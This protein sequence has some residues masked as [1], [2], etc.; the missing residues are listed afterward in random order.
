M[1][2]F[3]TIDIYF[4]IKYFYSLRIK[5]RQSQNSEEYFSELWDY[6]R[7]K[8]VSLEDV[9]NSELVSDIYPL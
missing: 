1:H 4:L 6:T 8:F 3:T 5:I 2:L 9:L 7:H